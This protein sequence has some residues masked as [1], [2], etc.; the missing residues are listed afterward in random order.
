[1]VSAKTILSAL[2]STCL[3]LSF[4]YPVIVC[5]NATGGY[6]P[7]PAP[8]SNLIISSTSIS[9]AIPPSTVVEDNI[10]QSNPTSTVTYIALNA[11]SPLTYINI[12][13]LQLANFPPGFSNP[14]GKVLLILQFNPDSNLD[15]SINSVTIDFKVPLST[16]R[17]AGPQS[18]SLDSLILQRNAGGSWGKLTT[19]VLGTNG[20]D[21]YFQAVSPGLSLFALTTPSQ[22]SQ[23]SGL[24]F[25]SA[26]SAVVI[27]SLVAV[28]FLL[29]HHRKLNGRAML[30]ESLTTEESNGR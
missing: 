2:L 22:Q 18:V 26:L 30:S 12:Q 24:T 17:S 29:I 7:T 28:A 5:A 1:M 16:I 8:S 13:I 6:P 9:I 15:T 10:S 19:Q 23:Y 11:S 14:S 20:Q 4:S 21:A 27:L 3:V 25:W